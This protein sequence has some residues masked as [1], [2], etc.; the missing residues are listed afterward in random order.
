MSYN[1]NALRTAFFS[2]VGI[3]NERL[4]IAGTLSTFVDGYM[5]WVEP[6]QPGPVYRKRHA[7]RLMVRCK[8]CN[9]TVSLGRLEQHL[10]PHSVRWLVLRGGECVDAVM[11]ADEQHAL[12]KARR[13]TIERERALVSVEIDTP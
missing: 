10:K 7:H 5:L 9:A 11:A 13:V 3:T 8:H 4:P 12:R 2:A 1:S 6:Q